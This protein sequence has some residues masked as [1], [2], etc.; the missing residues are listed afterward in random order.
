[1]NNFALIALGGVA[2]AGLVAYVAYLVGDKRRRRG[3][4]G[5][6]TLSS[7]PEAIVRAKRGR[8]R[9]LVAFVDPADP[10]SQALAEHVL[11]ATELA[12]AL[13]HFELVKIDAPAD[14]RQVVSHLAGK[15][16]LPKLVVP[17]LLALDIEGQKVSALEGSEAVPARVGEFLAMVRPGG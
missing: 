7:I 16:G 4:A 11:G 3:R 5:R 15:Y 10:P 14:D 9:V 2:A 12:G 1:M 8:R 6:A 17:T 13:R